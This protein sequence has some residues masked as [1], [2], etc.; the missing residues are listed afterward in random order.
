MNE[1]AI[2]IE[3]DETILFRVRK[4]WF[5]LVAQM[6][7]IVIVA[8]LP[9]VFYVTAISILLSRQLITFSYIEYF[10][11]FYCIWLILIWMTLFGI[12]TNYYL[13]I[14]TLT[15]KRLIAVDQRGFFH[16]KTASFPL[17]RL[18]DVTVSINGIIATFLDFGC[19]EIQTAGEDRKF[20]VFGLPRP[21]ILK[22]QILAASG[23]VSAPQD[24]N[25]TGGM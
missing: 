12:W 14:W 11:V 7:T 3:S 5:T 1:K 2:H 4:H 8:L 18:Q 21:E 22:A 13:D 24:Q 17:E 10:I 23:S 16:R 9:L 15:D 19:L 25:A 6:F 20:R